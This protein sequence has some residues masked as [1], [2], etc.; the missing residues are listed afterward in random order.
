MQ[1][2]AY[3]QAIGVIYGGWEQRY[4]GI[5][6]GHSWLVYTGSMDWGGVGGA[7]F[8]DRQGNV[9]DAL[10]T[11]CLLVKTETR[12]QKSVFFLVRTMCLRV[13]GEWHFVLSTESAGKL[14]CWTLCADW[15]A[16]FF[17]RNFTEN[18]HFEKVCVGED[19]IVSQLEWLSFS[20]I[21]FD[22]WKLGYLRQETVNGCVKS[23][24]PHM[25]ELCC[26]GSQETVSSGN[27]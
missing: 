5:S 26:H 11:T 17:Q 22:Y 8:E 13:Y 1:P 9:A 25:H 24:C 23:E 2:Q 12:K 14:H 4:R 16:F 6:S 20:V 7:W 15:T 19:G 3:H 27:D 18:K 21:L 10:I